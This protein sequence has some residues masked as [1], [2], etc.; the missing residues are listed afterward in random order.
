MPKVKGMVK[1]AGDRLM[2]ARLRLYLSRRELAT[3]LRVAESTVGCWERNEKPINPVKIEPLEHRGI[4]L[5]YILYG[6]GSIINTKPEIIAELY[7]RLSPDDKEIIEK[8][9]DTFSRRREA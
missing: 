6:N 9:I 1:G 2:Q 5:N 8:L 3:F 7:E 4:N